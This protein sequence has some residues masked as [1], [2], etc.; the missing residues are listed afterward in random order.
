M[1]K[2]KQN[3]K[4]L[5]AVSLLTTVFFTSFRA[6]EQTTKLKDGNQQ[7]IEKYQKPNV[8]IIY[9]DDQGSVDVNSYGAKDL[10]TPNMDYIVENGTSFTQFYASPVCSPSRASLMRHQVQNK[11]RGFLDL[12]IPWQKCL[13]TLAILLHILENGI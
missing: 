3:L 9:T 6:Q 5:L 10:V 13:K 11:K 12:N 2:L 4:L 8:I 1:I 7:T